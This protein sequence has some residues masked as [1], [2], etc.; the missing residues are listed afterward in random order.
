[1]PAKVPTKASGITFYQDDE[2]SNASPSDWWYRP[3]TGEVYTRSLTGEFWIEIVDKYTDPYGRGYLVGFCS[4]TQVG[5]SG[6]TTI[7]T[8]QFS[9][10]ATPTTLSSVFAPHGGEAI[11]LCASEA[12]YRCGGTLNGWDNTA[13]NTIDSI[14]KFTFATHTMTNNVAHMSKPKQNMYNGQAVSSTS[15]Y[16]FGGTTNGDDPLNEVERFIFAQDTTNSSAIATIDDWI[17]RCGGYNSTTA[18]YAQ[19]GNDIFKLTFA[20]DTGPMSISA[21]LP[22][23]RT[24]AGSYNSTLYGY[25]VG[26]YVSNTD[27]TTILRYSFSSDT[28]NA[29]LISA[30]LPTAARWAN[31]TMSSRKG[32]TLGR[33]GSNDVTAFIFA[34]DFNDA[35]HISD[36]PISGTTANN[37]V[38]TTAVNNGYLF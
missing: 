1:M 29:H 35:V 9:A 5:T 2:P 16:I 22:N 30:T 18:G 4:D 24:M 23:T 31:G 28:E 26:G 15:G 17:T 25:T 21:Y 32:Y 19:H 36:L 37:C 8:L 11:G 34:T 33:N 7:C 14:A 10:D 12:G 27:V 3:S 38:M 6:S 20:S 13:A